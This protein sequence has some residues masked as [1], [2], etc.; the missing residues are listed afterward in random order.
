[1]TAPRSPRRSS[2][3]GLPVTVSPARD[4]GSKMV[5]RRRLFA[6]VGGVFAIG[7]LLAF[8][9]SNGGSS[10]ASS[11]TSPARTGPRSNR[12]LLDA[13]EGE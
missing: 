6:A 4:G 12:R 7:M 2:G 3:A 10:L 1:M 5:N 11:Q 8:A 9:S 13:E